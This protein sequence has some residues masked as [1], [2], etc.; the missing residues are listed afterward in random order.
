MPF[1]DQCNPIFA[2]S[3]LCTR[4]TKHYNS[5]GKPEVNVIFTAVG[6]LFCSSLLAHGEITEVV[7]Q[8]D[9]KIQCIRFAQGMSKLLSKL[10]RLLAGFAGL[11]RV[12]QAPQGESQPAQAHNPGVLG[13]PREVSLQLLWIVEPERRAQVFA[14]L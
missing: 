10:Q 14:G 11:G 8:H 5:E 1:L 3:E 6:N 13:I 4:P 7:V 2:I 12:T 9:I